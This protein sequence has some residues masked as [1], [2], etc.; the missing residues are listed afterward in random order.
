ML[1]QNSI[2]HFVLCVCEYVSLQQ[3]LLFG[4]TFDLGLSHFRNRSYAHVGV[5]QNKVPFISLETAFGS[6]QE[7][8]LGTW[9]VVCV[10]FGVPPNTSS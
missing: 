1:L 4:M 2:A 3:L 10:F 7:F 6:Y 5:S 8:W 9:H